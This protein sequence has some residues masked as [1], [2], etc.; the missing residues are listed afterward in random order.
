MDKYK[1]ASFDLATE[2][3]YEII[4]RQL[5]SNFELVTL[6]TGTLE[7]RIEKARDADFII[8]ATG[9]KSCKKA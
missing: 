4:R 9:N 7:D 3:V 1:I 5:P 8:A 2:D 6:E